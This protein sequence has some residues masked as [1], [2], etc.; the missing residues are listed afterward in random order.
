MWSLYRRS[1]AYSLMEVLLV[2]SVIGLVAAIAIPSLSGV[3]DASRKAKLEADVKTLNQAIDIY[4]ANGGS[5]EEGVTPQEIL[6]KLKTTQ[7]AANA[8]TFVGFTGAMIDKRLAISPM[9]DGESDGFRAVWN[10]DIQ[11]F[12]I[13]QAGAGIGKFILDESL[14][15]VDYGT[16]E[17][18][19]SVLA[20]N[21]NPGWIWKYADATPPPPGG[22]TG[23]STGDTPDTTP[24]GSPGAINLLP[25]AYSLP[26]GI[27][28]AAE[29][30]MTVAVSNPNHPSTWI[31][32]S[33]NGAP[34]AEY[35]GAVSVPA[36]A[37]LIAYAEGDP[38]QFIKSPRVYA[39]YRSNAAPPAP[40]EPLLPPVITLSSTTFSDSTPTIDISIA[41][42]N[43][44]GVSDLLYLLQAKGEAAPAGT[45]GFEP[46][47]GAFSA[48]VDDYPEGF[49]VRA[50]AKSLDPVQYYDSPVATAQTTAE[51]FGIPV[52]GDV[53]FVLDASSSMN[54]SFGGLSRYEATIREAIASINRLEGTQSFNVAMFAKDL[55][56][57]DGSFTLH[58]ATAENKQ[59]MIDLL[60][61]IDNG[62]GTNYEVALALPLMFDPK[63]KTV[64]FLT[65]GRPSN[66]WDY[67]D[68][69]AALVS[70]GIK[71][72]G[73]FLGGS[74]ND[75]EKLREISDATGGEFI[76]PEAPTQ[77]AMN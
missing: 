30:P 27:Y 10:P 23:V 40:P 55:H 77:A 72:N 42:P 21:D 26:T 18:Q 19:A 24:P 35:T 37:R 54:S 38:A 4:R 41:N 16:E 52:E 66:T 67:T 65:D 61:T 76:A 17:R 62:S 44:A 39:T 73:V 11:H 36:G 8:V 9:E 20:Y 3:H 29:F 48:S 69:L 31:M 15:E 28:D 12:E 1:R 43:P 47:G 59:A 13:S 51:F 45:S 74:E 50:Y 70:A 64:F 25:P 63:P 46:Y 57:T 60:P 58:P 56:W 32:L 22:I 34:F 68:E 33:V 75:Q 6:D 5:F 53:L 14:A 49:V 71:V 2:V 7:A